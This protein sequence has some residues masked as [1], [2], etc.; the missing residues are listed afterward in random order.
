VRT[1]WDVLAGRDGLGERVLVLDDVGHYEAIAVV[2]AL[3]ASGKQV[4]FVTPH[5]AVGP[6]VAAR[7][8]GNELVVL[9]ASRGVAL[10]RILPDLLARTSHEAHA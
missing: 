2:D 5:P 3:H 9:K 8:H 6:L 7:L 4:V 10:E 1:S